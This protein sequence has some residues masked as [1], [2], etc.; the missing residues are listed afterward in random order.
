MS[1]LLHLIDQNSFISLQS[2]SMGG[3]KIIDFLCDQK[4]K[5]VF[6]YITLSLS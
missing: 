4:E 6:E 5:M 2:N 3:W 1:S